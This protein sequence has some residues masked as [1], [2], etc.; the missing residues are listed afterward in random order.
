MSGYIEGREL[1]EAEGVDQTGYVEGRELVVAEGVC[2][3]G[4]VVGMELVEAM[5]VCQDTLMEGNQQRLWEYV[6][7]RR[8]N[9]IS[10]DIGSNRINSGKGVVKAMGVGSDRINVFGTKAS[11]RTER[12][13]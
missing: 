12:N 2:Q 3:T 4:Y 1:E 10:G 8:G 13:T 7:I 6:R 5:G 11:N 9:R